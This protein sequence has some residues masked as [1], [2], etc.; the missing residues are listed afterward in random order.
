MADNSK[1]HCAYMWGHIALFNGKAATPCCRYDTH[2]RLKE[3]ADGI[4]DGD[5]PTID[6]SKPFAGFTEAIHS[7]EWETLR[8]NADAGIREPGCW[9]CYEDEAQ[10]N[11]SLRQVAN[12][13]W[14]DWEEEEIVKPEL[15]YLEIN[16]GNFCNLACN[17]CSSDNSNL[18]H[19]DDAV[20]H[21]IH[22]YRR[23]LYEPDHQR[24]I[25]LNYDDYKDATLIKFV[26][27]EPMIHPKFI[28]L[29]DFLIEHDLQ[30]TINLQV[31]TNASWLPKDKVLSRLKQFANV[32][33]SLSVD[34]IK[35]VNDYSR[36]PSKW[37]V[38]DEAV[39]EWIKTSHENENFFVRWEP[40]I[41]IYN[42][43][44]IPEMVR[45]WVDTTMAVTGQ[46]FEKAVYDLQADD[47]NIIFNNVMW[48]LY[49]KPN[50]LPTSDFERIR[51]DSTM[52]TMYGKHHDKD[53]EFSTLMLNKLEIKLK[54]AKRF[55][56]SDTDAGAVRTFF[57]FTADIDKLRDN[58][59]RATL[60]KLYKSLKLALKKVDN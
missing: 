5:L 41:S 3:D 29:L 49:L 9:K 38:V 53:N 37:E 42:S 32:S 12:R 26:G 33:I 1:T 40:T 52:A 10:G 45:W 4:E 16:L 23:G 7:K 34:G 55:I 59:F 27:G 56:S 30:N 22:E 21:T 36:W 18:W 6:M 13:M 11:D 19:K 35:Q 2:I 24:G 15:R 14:E 20:L 50:L 28:T 17:I 8:A 48:P 44:H 39:R 58:N 47:L 46:P 31:F 60:P 54:D 43:N 25:S 51:I 57:N